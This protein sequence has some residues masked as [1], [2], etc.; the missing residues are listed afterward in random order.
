MQK[1]KIG[2]NF[3]KLY[4]CTRNAQKIYGLIEWNKRKNVPDNVS[5]NLTEIEQ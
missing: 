5:Q 3:E 4:N 1:K 2:M